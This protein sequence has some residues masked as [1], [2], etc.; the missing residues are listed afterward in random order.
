MFNNNNDYKNNKKTSDLEM[1]I[2]FERGF[3]SNEKQ[4]IF[5]WSY[6]PFE[7]GVKNPQQICKTE[8]TSKTEHSKLCLECSVFEVNSVLQ[9]HRPLK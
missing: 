1:W 9:I 4:I 2:M 5:Y 7:K 3:L 6:F 8:F